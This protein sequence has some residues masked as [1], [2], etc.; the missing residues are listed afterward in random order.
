MAQILLK[1]GTYSQIEDAAQDGRLSQGEPYFATDTKQFLIGT[2]PN[3]FIEFDPAS[4]APV[5]AAKPKSP[6]KFINPNFHVQTNLV[7][8]NNMSQYTG[9][10]LLQSTN[11]LSVGAK[12]VIYDSYDKHCNAVR[13][14]SRN[15]SSTQ[16]AALVQRIPNLYAFQGKRVY[17]SMYIKADSTKKVGVFAR[18][19]KGPTSS[20]NVIIPGEIKEIQGYTGTTQSMPAEPVRFALDIP[21][22]S[23]IISLPNRDTTPYSDYPGLEIYIVFAAGV[24]SPLYQHCPVGQHHGGATI[25]GLHI[26]D[27]YDDVMHYAEPL[28]QSETECKTLFHHIST[29]GVSYYMPYVAGQSADYGNFFTHAPTVPFMFIPRHTAVSATLANATIEVYAA[30]RHLVTCRVSPVWTNMPAAVKV[31]RMN[32]RIDARARYDVNTVVS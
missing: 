12:E 4:I 18:Q 1:R 3:T 28:L 23:P 10:G 31:S 5:A 11:G 16:Y 6:V 30:T 26:S 20:A 19:F 17:V 21:Q 7:T 15:P 27:D 24:D 13:F 14:L 8:A 32:L 29:D 2:G 22:V 25:T 9:W